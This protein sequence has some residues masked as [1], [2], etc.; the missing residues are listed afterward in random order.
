MFAE[1]G[2]IQGQIDWLPIEEIAGVLEKLVMLRDQTIGL[3]QQI[4]GMADVMRGE[5]AN[6]YEGVGQTQVKA[7]FASVRVQALSEEFARFVT[8]LQSLKAEVIAKH[9]SPETIA[10]M[11]NMQES[12]DLEI[13]PKAIELIKSPDEVV[14]RVEIKSETMA[15]EDYAQLQSERQNYL[16]GLSTFLQAATPLIQQ[17]PRS[18]PFLM[19]ML[20]WG[21]AGFK[22][23]SDIEGVL[24]QAIETMSQPEQQKEPEPSDIEKQGQQQ[25][26]L[27]QLRQQGQAASDQ[28]K[29]QETQQARQF[30][31][32]MDVATRQQEHSMAMEAQQQETQSELTVIAAK[33]E[34]DVQTELLTS[35][36]NAEQADRAVQG[37]IELELGKAKIKIMEMRES[38]LIDRETKIIEKVIDSADK[39]KDRAVTAAKP[40]PKT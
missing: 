37:N 17:D 23:S 3:L 9:F 20:K 4:T 30:D 39:D 11:A 24:D 18:L 40:E 32:Q 15:M 34:A 28:R 36:I 1:K 10:K 2:G 35:Q 19:E 5:L 22:G 26:Q 29:V 33:M 12:P 6:Q 21:M 27:E 7:K 13:L 38:K 16:N 31:M 25:M 14:Y 8:D